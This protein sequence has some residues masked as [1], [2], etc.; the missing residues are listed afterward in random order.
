MCILRRSGRRRFRLVAVK[1]VAVDRFQSRTKYR[2][3]G[4]A[5]QQMAAD[6]R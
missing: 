1:G 4:C 5:R 3:H 2:L 6:R